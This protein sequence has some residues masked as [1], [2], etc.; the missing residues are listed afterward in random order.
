MVGQGACSCAPSHRASDASDAAG[1]ALAGELRA[2][3]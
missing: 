1:G 3:V 2:S